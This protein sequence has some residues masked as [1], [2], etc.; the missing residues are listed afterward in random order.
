M[1]TE[2]RRLYV[3]WLAA[4]VGHGRADLAAELVASVDG[5]IWSYV[6]HYARVRLPSDA[7]EDLYQ[8]GVYAV[9]YASRKY[10]PSLSAF[11]TY[12][13]FHIKRYMKRWLFRFRFPVTLPT[14]LATYSKWRDLRR[15]VVR[16]LERS[17]ELDG[18]VDPVDPSKGYL[19]EH[20]LRDDAESFQPD[21]LCFRRDLFD[22][23]FGV[24]DNREREVIHRRLD[25][26]SLADIAVD[27]GGAFR[28]GLGKWGKRWK[29][30]R[31]R[32]LSRERIRQIQ[33][34]ALTKMIWSL[35]RW[36][37]LGQ[38]SV[39]GYDGTGASQYSRHAQ[40]RGAVDERRARAG[41]RRSA[42]AALSSTPLGH[43]PG[44]PPRGGRRRG[45]DR[46]IK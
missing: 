14:Q 11:S 36:D 44:L 45:A 20:F 35:R 42:S 24:L 28:E 26:M 1:D 30:G 17:V 23:L 21:E 39:D 34:Q 2:A 15:E 38:V 12:L 29:K 16:A 13:D 40:G 9:L 27:M 32:P 5:I 37:L 25:G 3:N 31:G 18:L 8:E 41:V 22:H 10:D 19:G 6:N 43:R 4:E 7:R 33:V 46:S